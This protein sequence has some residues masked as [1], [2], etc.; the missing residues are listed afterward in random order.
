MLYLVLVSLSQPVL[1]RHGQMNTH[2]LASELCSMVYLLE[3]PALSFPSPLFYQVL[4]FVFSPIVS[5][6]IVFILDSFVVSATLL[7][8]YYL[9]LHFPCW[10][11]RISSTVF[12]EY[13]F[14]RV[15]GILHSFHLSLLSRSLFPLF[16]LI[17]TNSARNTN[18]L[19]SL[20]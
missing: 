3:P 7:H 11:F 5:H 12:L 20:H 14:L 17:S 15:A 10:V 13:Q 8:F 4:S 16:Y 2:V 6:L 19:Q 18:Q 1:G 9:Y